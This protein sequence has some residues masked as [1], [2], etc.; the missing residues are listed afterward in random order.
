MSIVKLPVG[1][2]NEMPYDHR[3]G[4]TPGYV[5]WR[6]PNCGRCDATAAEFAAFLAFCRERGIEPDR[7]WLDLLAELE[8][9]AREGGE[10]GE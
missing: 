9:K 2:R 6:C 4:D 7:I 8:A 1:T 10:G 5:R 3:R